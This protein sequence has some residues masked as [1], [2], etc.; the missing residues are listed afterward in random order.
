[1]KRFT[2]RIH[3]KDDIRPLVHELLAEN[4]VSAWKLVSSYIFEAS[5]SAQIISIYLQQ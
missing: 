3:I 4:E 5:F 2:F 1:M